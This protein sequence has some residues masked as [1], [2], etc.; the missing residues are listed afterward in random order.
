VKVW[1][2][3]RM[4]EVE[5]ITVESVAG[6]FSEEA[7]AVEWVCGLPKDRDISYCTDDFEVDEEWQRHGDASRKDGNG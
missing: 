7:L 3:V 6:V 4:R 2:V 5:G 1:V